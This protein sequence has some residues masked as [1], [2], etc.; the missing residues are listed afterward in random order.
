MK[1]LLESIIVFDTDN[2]EAIYGS[3]QHLILGLRT[4]E[5]CLTVAVLMITKTM[6]INCNMLW[7]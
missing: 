1:T 4:L 3:P 6:P 5:G 2:P 7:V